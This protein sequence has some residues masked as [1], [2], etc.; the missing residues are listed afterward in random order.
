MGA[1]AK[2]GWA[3]KHFEALGTEWQAFIDTDP[4]GLRLN[5]DLDAQTI[6]VTFKILKPMCPKIALRAGD[7]VQ[8][9]RAALDYVAAELVEAHGGDSGRSQFPIYVADARLSEM[10]VIGRKR[11][12]QGHSTRSRSAATNGHLSRAFSLTSERTR[13]SA[14]RSMPSTTCRTE[15]STAPS[16]QPSG[17]HSFGSSKTS[18][19]SRPPAP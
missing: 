19:R 5:R 7:V 11:G 8:N 17:H 1:K 15:T 6:S 4:Y 12:D 2:L 3:E 14:T 9:L 13:R 18:S 10:Y 16:R